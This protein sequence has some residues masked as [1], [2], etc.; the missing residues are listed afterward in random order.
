MKKLTYDTTKTIYAD[1]FGGKY[2]V[3]DED[4]K[5]RLEAAFATVSDGDL[6]SR[7]HKCSCDLIID[8]LSPNTTRSTA[9]EA[10]LAIAKLIYEKKEAAGMLFDALQEAA[11]QQA[12]VSGRQDN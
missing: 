2:P 10:A 6:D 1:V 11:L 12:P 7:L 9:I 8:L 4:Q 5:F 3:C